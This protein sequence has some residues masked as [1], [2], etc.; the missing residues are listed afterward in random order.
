VRQ[1]PAA[2]CNYLTTAYSHATNP[3]A[4][5]P[6]TRPQ[7]GLSQSAVSIGCRH[8]TECVTI[9]SAVAGTSNIE[10]DIELFHRGCC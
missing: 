5:W 8:N 2:R 7:R 1:D 6:Y 3:S 10:R 9:S 4:G